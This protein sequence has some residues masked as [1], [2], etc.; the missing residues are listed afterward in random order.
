MITGWDSEPHNLWVDGPAQDAFAALWRTFAA[1]YRGLPPNALSFDLVNEPPALGLRGFTREAHEAVIR[2]TV[3]EIRRAD[4]SRPIAIDGL[5][6]GHLAM[7]E[8]ADLRVIHSGRGYQPMSVSH[9]RAS[10][11]PEH[12]HL[13]EPEYPVDYDGRRWD[14]VALR[15]FYQPWRDLA[16]AGVPV[17]I[18]EF[19]CYDYT[20]DDVAQR[21]FT[22]LLGIFAQER[23]GYA[24][25][26][27]AGAFGVVGH[28]RPG[29]RFE[30]RDGWMVD[31]RLLEL[32]RAHRV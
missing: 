25:W 7:P 29:A 30:S 15:E 10:W 13:P 19:G 3:A 6:G 8:L 4:P 2:R 18:G 17:H 5:D 9:Y 1:R 28:R 21:W 27:F 26:E 22:D 24:L 20:P 23:W 32:L 14:A 16:G 11:W 12:E 31:V